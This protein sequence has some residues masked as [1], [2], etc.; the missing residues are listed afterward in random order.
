[1][2]HASNIDLNMDLNLR[3][4]LCSQTSIPLRYIIIVL[5]TVFDLFNAPALTDAPPPLQNRKKSYHGLVEK[6]PL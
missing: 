6:Y 5:D 2:F 3:H 1:M 4:Q